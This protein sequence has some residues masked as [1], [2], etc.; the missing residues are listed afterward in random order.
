MAKTRASRDGKPTKARAIRDLLTAD[1]TM[2]TTAVISALKGKGIKV[3]PNH[4]YLIKS[5]TKQRKRRA[6]REEVAATTERNGFA[7]A[8]K[9]VSR[10]MDVARDLGG[11]RNLKSLVDVLSQ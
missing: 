8:A 1:P 10:V 5:K 3:S 4:V 2:K 11:L 7:G 6:R 9:A